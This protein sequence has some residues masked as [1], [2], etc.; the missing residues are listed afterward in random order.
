MSRYTVI[1]RH[2]SFSTHSCINACECR[3]RLGDEQPSRVNRL[4]RIRSID[5]RRDRGN[6]PA[7]ITRRLNGV[8][9]VRGSITYPPCSNR[10]CSA[11]PLPGRTSNRRAGRRTKNEKRT[12]NR[13]LGEG[14]PAGVFACVFRFSFFVFRFSLNAPYPP[15]AQ[16]ILHVELRDIPS[17][18]A[19]PANVN[20]SESHALP[21]VAPQAHIASAD[22]S[23]THQRH[24][25]TLMRA[26]DV[27]AVA[28]R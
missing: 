5:L 9:V 1:R 20:D 19:L 3:Q 26:G 28:S 25:I 7:E 4:G 23:V 22:R 12:T 17:T 18:E 14:Y 13:D 11:P 15:R 2:A 27:V 24:E 21:V 16:G 8:H 10:S 6:L